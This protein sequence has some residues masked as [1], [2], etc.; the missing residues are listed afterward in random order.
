M[1]DLIVDNVFTEIKNADKEVEYA[2]WDKLSFEVQEFNVGAFHHPKIRHLFNRKT[3]LTYTGLLPYIK[4]ILDEQEVE[5]N[6]IDNRTKHVSNANYQLV[7]YLDKDKKIPFK[8]R[9]YQQNIVDNCEDRAVIQACTG[10]GKRLSLDT[11]ILTPDGFKKLRDIHTG[12]IIFDEDGNPTTVLDESP[13]VLTD[14]YQI[15]FQDG[16]SIKC[17]KDHL[18]K[19]AISNRQFD[20]NRCMVTSTEQMLNIGVIKHRRNG[21]NIYQMAIPVNKPIQFK[22]R[23]LFLHPYLLGLLLGNGEFSQ[24]TISFTNVEEDIINRL[25]ELIKPFGGFKQRAGLDQIQYFFYNRPD[26]KPG[27]NEFKNYIYS[28][29]KFCKSIG[30]FIPKEYLLSSVEDRLEL[31][32][33]LIDTDGN[34]NEKG[35]IRFCTVSPQL[36]DDFIFLIRS[37]GYRT[38]IRIDIRKNNPVYNIYIHGCDDKLFSSKKHKQRFANRTWHKNHR[39]DILKIVDIKKLSTKSEMKCLTVDSPQHTYICENFIVT[40]NTAMLAA[41]VAKFNVKPVAVLADKLSLC[42]QLQQEFSKFLGEDIG[43][44]G[45]GIKDQKDITIYSVQSATEDMV[46]DAKLMMV[47]ECFVYETIVQLANGIKKSIGDIVENFHEQERPYRIVTFNH[48]T[49]EKEN[50]T[51]TAVSKTPLVKELVVVLIKDKANKIIKLICTDDHPFY[52]KETNIYTPARE[53]EEGLTVQLLDNSEGTIFKIVKTPRKDQYVYDIEVEGNHN[54]YANGVLVH[55]CHHTPADTISQVS[56]WCK[57][58]YYRIGVS[59]TPW[60][61]DGADLLIDAVF[62]KQNKD[63]AITASYLIQRGYLVP[64]TIYWVQQRQ[65]FKNK[66]SYNALYTEAI[67]NNTERN[68]NIVK[69]AYQMRKFKDA[70]ILILIQRVEHGSK[71]LK[72]LKDC[73]PNESFSM[74][75][76]NAKTGK[77]TLVR[78]NTIEFLSG[79]DDALKRQAVIQ[80]TRERKCK[81]LIA[82]TIADE[83]LDIPAI[84]CVILGGGGRSSTRAFQRIGRAIRLY[85]NPETGEDKKMAIVFDF[86]DY[87]PQLRRHAR[88]RDKMYKQEPE[89]DIKNFPE[90]LLN[91]NLPKV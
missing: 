67:V 84:S 56:R 31:A 48:E 72:M 22:K 66:K 43:L 71:L 35:H 90:H 17:C 57:D 63:L 1:I 75:V 86:C 32:R 42:T 91:F 30:K 78:C 49:G 25:Q 41:L 2:I 89:W 15:T 73:L 38:S 47:D 79:Q 33:G 83:G 19:Y 6:I 68:E 60:R 40:H 62:S 51:I 34:I 5:Y 61:D 87:T 14:E 50:K 74:T 59:A 24:S 55:N 81:I 54:F 65:V 16:T 37:L 45:G 3:K 23:K 77:D 70:I 53:L 39:Y 10:A 18:W 28:T 12:D 26:D 46:K 76:Q 8:L 11:D 13:I 9:D 21:R 20:L 52:I 80:A 44:V 88:I 4:E 69:I 36:R 27:E 82:S 64:C 85:T 58:A 29:F 7:D